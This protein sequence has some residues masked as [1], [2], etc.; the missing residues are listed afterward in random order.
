LGLGL[1][2][3]TLALLPVDIFLVSSTVDQSNGLK[4]DWATPQVIETMTFTMSIVYYGKKKKL[5]Y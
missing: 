1:V 4:K 5:I 3:S 2:F